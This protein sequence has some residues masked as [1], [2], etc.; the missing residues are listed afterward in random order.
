MKEISRN[1]TL[2]VHAQV[3]ALDAQAQELLDA[4]LLATKS[5][6]APYSD[7]HVGAAVQLANGELLPGCNQENAAFP[8]G[9]CAERVAFFTAGAFY[10]GV[11]IESVAIT[12]RSASKADHEPAAPC[13]GCLQVM[14]DVELRQ[15]KPI[16]VLLKGSGDAVYEA[17]SIAHFLPFGFSLIEK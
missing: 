7:F 15:D 8:S 5:A 17:D 14:R 6:Y 9:L 3:D 1:C 11:P 12:I 2:R 10:P 13:G 16:R 4:A